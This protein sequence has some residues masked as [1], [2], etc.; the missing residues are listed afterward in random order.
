MVEIKQ[1]KFWYGVTKI[2]SGL[3]AKFIFKR[4]FIRNEIKGKSGPFVVI[5]N[6]EAAFDFVN[7]IG[8]TKTPMHF[9]ISHSFF[10]TIPVKGIMEKTGMI[11]KQQFQTSI[12]DISRMKAV[13]DQG[14]ILALYPAGLMSED[15]LPTPTPIATTQ[16]LK[17]LG[18]DIYVAKTQGSYFVMPK[19]RKNGFR[20]GKTTI[21][22]YKLISKEELADIELAEL[23]KRVNEAL[24]FDAYRD[25]EANPVKY[26]GADNIEGLENVLYMC[27]HCKAEFS[28]RV[29]NKNTIYCEKCGFT[30]ES[31]KYGFLHKIGE[32]GEEIRYVSDWSRLIYNDFKAKIESGEN[33]ELSSDATIH[34][35][36]YDKR[37]FVEVGSG[38]LSFCTD[39]L[40]FKG[41]VNG[42][43]REMCVPTST[44]PSLP[45]KPGKYIE[46]QHGKEIFRCYLNDG[47][48]VMKFVN[49]VKI[50]YE[51]NAHMHAEHLHR[52]E[53][54]A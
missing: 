44:F 53:Q 5:A 15:G 10:S 23:D 13:I 8:A 51:L 1:N 39:G 14:K 46:L 24:S 36:D 9:V 38:N 11:D 34:M 32:V 25:Q 19:W 2:A 17:W 33:V 52:V 48:L 22:I 12:K 21:D 30:E 50:S 45:F 54:H 4:K 35:I 16:F 18:A 41:T 47:A 40:H 37:K 6:H 26:K 28:M 7:L 29:K 43:E 20:P 49:F 3:T 42:E 27:P 31:D